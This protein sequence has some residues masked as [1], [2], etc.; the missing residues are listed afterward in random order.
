MIGGDGEDTLTTNVVPL[1][2]DAPGHGI[3]IQLGETGNDNLDAT[4]TLQGGEPTFRV[5]EEARQMC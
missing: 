3:A 4:V 5:L 2:S 1:Q